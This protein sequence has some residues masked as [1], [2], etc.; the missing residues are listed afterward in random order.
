MEEEIV[1]LAY[2]LKELA[3]RPASPARDRL[4]RRFAVKI[5]TLVDA[6]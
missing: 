5:T 1:L 4:L 2:R 6:A 3:E